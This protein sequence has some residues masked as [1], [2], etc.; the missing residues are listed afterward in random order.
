MPPS[1]DQKNFSKRPAKAGNIFVL[2]PLYQP[3]VNVIVTEVR[4]MMRNE[5]SQDFADM[6]DHGQTVPL[7]ICKCKRSANYEGPLSQGYSSS[8]RRCFFS[9]PS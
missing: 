9:R 7:N 8:G 6:K 1:L 5:P 3:A 4:G 2:F